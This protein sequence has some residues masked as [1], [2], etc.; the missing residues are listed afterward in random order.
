MEGRARVGIALPGM[1]PVSEVPHTHTCCTVVEREWDGPTGAW[2][3]HCVPMP[4]PVS[5]PKECTS[6]EAYDLLGWSE[7][8]RGQT[9]EAPTQQ[10]PR[11]ETSGAESLL[12]DAL[13][14]LISGRKHSQR[15]HAAG[16]PPRLRSRSR[17]YLSFAAAGAYGYAYCGVLRTIERSFKGR[18]GWARFVSQLRG[19]SGTSAGA[20]A[21]VAV[22]CGASPAQLGEFVVGTSM[23]SLIC[24][25]I[26]FALALPP[27][28]PDASEAEPSCDA[29][30]SCGPTDLGRSPRGQLPPANGL[31]LARRREFAE[32]V[33]ASTQH[34]FAIG[35]SRRGPATVS[36]PDGGGGG[37]TLHSLANAAALV[38][39]QGLARGRRGQAR[40]AGASAGEETA[41]RHGTDGI[42]PRQSAKA[43]PLRGLPSGLLPGTFL[44]N[45]ARAALQ[46]WSGDPDVTFQELCSSTGRTLQIVATDLDACAALIFSPHTTPDVPVHVA[47]RASMSVPAVFAPVE[48]R[49]RLLVDGGVVNTPALALTPPEETLA[50]A[51]GV[52]RRCERSVGAILTRVAHASTVAQTD[53]VRGAIASCRAAQ[54]TVAQP[55]VVTLEPAPCIS[56][57]GYADPP[58]ARAMTVRYGEE[59]LMRWIGTVLACAALYL[60]CAGIL[61]RRDACRDRAVRHSWSPSA[62]GEEY[63]CK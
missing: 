9:S 11:E 61:R 44:T 24:H 48:W 37:G 63:V 3:H 14:A 51:V 19:A 49:G 1:L 29:T 16:E 43:D 28:H 23:K 50:F 5:V 35:E 18:G 15:I 32:A 22:V 6:E 41:P 34:R 31:N 4:R 57:T 8:K 60:V 42:S 36:P 17:R 27:P 30:G 52:T 38:I 7:E 56:G 33:A 47:L 45:L 54:G 59:T 62:H 55:I 10:V 46:L 53:L 40:A 2:W 13:H 39:Q 58:R 25:D 12:L 20:L 21:A 26:A